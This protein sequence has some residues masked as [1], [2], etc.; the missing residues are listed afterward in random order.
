LSGASQGYWGYTTTGSS[1]IGMISADGNNTRLLI[2][3]SG[4][5][6]IGTTTP[7]KRFQVFNTIADDQFRISYDSTRYADFQ[8]DSAGD[9][10]IDAQGGDVRLNDESLYVCAGGSCPSGISS[11]T[12]NAIIEGDLYVANDNPAAMGLA[13]STFE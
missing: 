12:G 3:D 7:N 1:G 13:T 10:I 4:N 9:L 5:V 2:T 11:G 6:G 8:V